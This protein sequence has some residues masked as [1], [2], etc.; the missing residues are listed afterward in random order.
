[1]GDWKYKDAHNQRRRERYAADPNYRDEQKR[2][3]AERRAQNRSD[4]GHLL[5]ELN[6][7]KV[8]VF[9]IGEIAEYCG[10]TVPRVRGAFKRGRFPNPSFEGKHIYVTQHQLDLI[11]DA[12]AQPETPDSEMR[13]ILAENWED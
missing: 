1:M 12:F 7:E 9:K 4:D 10:V 2:R 6:G 5:K 3:A 11:K 8:K 13:E